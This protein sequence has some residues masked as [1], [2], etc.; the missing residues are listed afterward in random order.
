[1]LQDDD[2]RFAELSSERRCLLDLDGRWQRFDAGWAEVLGWPQHELAGRPLADIVHP[3][4]TARLAEVHA[5]LLR[6]ERITDVDLRCAHRDGGHRWLRWSAAPDL[7]GGRLA[8]VAC[9]VTDLLVEREAARSYRDAVELSQEGIVQHDA[10][11]TITFVNPWLTTMLRTSVDTLVGRPLLDLFDPSERPVVA[12]G[13]AAIAAGEID[14][15]RAERQLRRAD[16]TSLWVQVA[17]RAARDDTGR[18]ATVTGIIT[19]I[20]QRKLQ[21]DAL[22]DAHEQLDEAQRLA[23]LG[24]WQEDQRT[25]RRTWSPIVYEIFG[26]DPDRF[27]PT[28]AFADTMPPE[29]RA[30]V[31]AAHERAM[32]EGASELTHRIVRPDGSERIVRGAMRLERDDDG[33]P[34]R[35]L[36]TV[37]DVTE[38]VTAERA[39][40]DSQQQLQRVLGATNDGWWD[41]DVLAGT[42]FYSDRWWEIHGYRPGELPATPTLW[43][44]LAHPGDLD[45]YDQELASIVK[46]RQT[47][48][49]VAGRVVHKQGHLVSIVVR[50]IVDYD[51]AG[52][53]IRFSGV[54]IDVTEAKQAELAKEGFIS[55]VSHELRTPLTSIGGAL[56]L[57]DAGR[58][59]PVPPPMGQLIDVAR[60]NT[61]RLRVLIDDLLT[62]DRLVTDQ[63]TFELSEEPIVTLVEQV[64]V[65]NEHFGLGHGVDYRFVDDAGS[66]CVLVDPARLQQ[67]VANLLSNAAKFAPT[68]TT[69]EVRALSVDDRVRVEVVDTGPGVPEELG[70]RIFDRFVQADPAD[71]RSRGGTGLGLAISR[72]IVERLDGEL[73][74]ESRPGRTCFW[75][76]LPRVVGDRG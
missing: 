24:H 54:N 2:H 39:L 22:A 23:R 66:A 35:F 72:E 3:D 1:M 61:R 69:V 31:E 44:D 58:T 16:G 27:D 56:E 62:I 36:G 19:D 55:T 70:E 21:Q 18:V 41:I 10:D 15:V 25:G 67:V 34:A 46:H 73:R 17:V 74:Y 76:E 68:G 51:D 33:A 71:H 29:D 6:G 52:R 28:S 7:D 47:S 75:F 59:G 40:R 49:T 60:R 64:V 57:I 63:Q 8:C 48:Y 43:R 13:V 26:V 38:T 20:T 65:D 5:R 11:G 4:D 14:T 42:A 50:G 53:P 12:A 30:A 45:R 37:Q 32:V 9:D